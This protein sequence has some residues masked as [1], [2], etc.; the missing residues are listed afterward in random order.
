MGK[1]FK[2]KQCNF[3]VIAYKERTDIQLTDLLRS[4]DHVAFTEI[5]NRYWNKLTAIAYNHTKDKSAAKEIV[6][7]LFVG[8]WNRKDILDIKTLNGYLA[9]AVK[10]AVYK[11][12]ERERRRR[13]IE[14]QEFSKSDFMEIDQEIETRFL[15]EYI[16]GQV[17]QLPEKCR[18]VFNYSRVKGM[19]NPEIAEEMN[20]SVR[21]VEGH[22]NK[23]LKAIRNGLKD[24]G[25]LTL[26]V[27]SSLYELLK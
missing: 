18:M 13:E 4:G 7:E 27:S 15:Q 2:F 25:M 24:S 23:G 17:E 9:T 16:N 5:Y 8:L 19:S 20:I 14:N 12:I 21:T 1:I 10:F 22:L 11:K 26:I 6:Q 3:F